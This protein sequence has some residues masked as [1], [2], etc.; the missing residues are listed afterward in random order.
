MS[1]AVTPPRTCTTLIVG[2]STTVRTYAEE[3]QRAR[4]HKH[5]CAALASA[6]ASR[7]VELT[8]VAVTASAPDT[9]PALSGNAAPRDRKGSEIVVVTASGTAVPLPCPRPGV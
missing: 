8:D 6:A 3:W 7:N 5:L 1:C 4:L 9:N 2:C